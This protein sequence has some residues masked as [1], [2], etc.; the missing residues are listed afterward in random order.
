MVCVG[1]DQMTTILT[2]FIIE[3]IA[4]TISAAFQKNWGMVLYG[5]GGA[6]LNVGVLWMK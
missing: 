2:I 1:V 3:F 6:I 5:I 4:L